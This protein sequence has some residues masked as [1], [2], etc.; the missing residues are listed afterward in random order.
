MPRFYF[1]IC[2][3]D[4]IATDEVG[5]ELPDLHAA[6][7]EATQSLADMAK[8]MLPGID[9]QNIGVVVRNERGPL[10]KAAIIYDFTRH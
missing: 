9:G 10:F 7:I 5:L 4:E 1:D 8:D 3:N 2:E 6:E